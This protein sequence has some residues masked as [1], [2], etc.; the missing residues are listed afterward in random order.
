VSQTKFMFDTNAINAIVKQ[1]IDTKRLDRSHQ[2][3][4]SPVQLSE[5]NKTRNP[6]TKEKLLLG[7]KL[8]ANSISLW[9]TN[10]ES[11]PWG[12]FPWGGAPWGAHG[13]YYKKIKTELSTFKTKRKNRGNS[14]DALIIETCLIQKLVLV[15][16]DPEVQEVSSQLGVQCVTV[17]DFLKKYAA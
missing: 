7:L 4:I 10:I 15:S 13:G 2:Y 8:M 12:E 3:F 6:A 1:G 16:N 17:S 9:I 14:S 5:L 11:A